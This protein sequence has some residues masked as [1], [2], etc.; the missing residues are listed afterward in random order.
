MLMDMTQGKPGKVLIKFTVPLMVS[1]VFQQFYSI[2]DS[3]IA[4]KY[5]GSNA[6]SAVGSSYPITMIFMAIALGMNIGCSVVISQLFGAKENAKVK[7][8]ATTTIISA[9]AIS[10][11]LSI[12]GLVL[13]PSLM[14][15]INTPADIFADGELYLNIYIYGFVFLFLYNISTGIFT[16]LGDSR[17]PLYFLIFSSVFN[18]VLDYILVKYFY[19]GV[20]GVAWA[21]FIAQ[22]ISCIG[23]TVV[24][25]K[26]LKAMKCETKPP[27]FEWSMLAKISRLA[28]PSML[29]Q[30]F[31]S[32]GHL[33]IQGVVNSFQSNV[34]AGYTAAAKLNTFWITVIHAISNGLSSFSAQNY[35][36]GQ[37]KRIHKGVKA[38]ILIGVVMCIP[39]VATYFLASRFMIGLFLPEG[40]TEEIYRV[41]ISFLKIV[42]PFYAVITLKVV[43]D[44]VLRGV[45]RV[46]A[47]TTSSFVDL[48]VRTVLSYVFAAAFGATGIWISWPVSWI[49]SCL[50]SFA[51]YLHSCKS[52]LKAK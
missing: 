36:A 31:V 2:A 42:S 37:T 12:V 5:A 4:G 8:A 23:A 39:F 43:F 6:L 22:S 41:G 19:L 30:S 18:V 21:T 35:G 16:A 34:I 10:V 11:V 51:F 38:A 15:L 48:L 47:F 13:A 20:A 27:V 26:R 7:T 14:R 3:V 29:Q 45:G 49:V 28:L 24:I 52:I 50:V 1:V 25:L 44:G 33:L 40:S 9:F 32:V 17:T 46:T